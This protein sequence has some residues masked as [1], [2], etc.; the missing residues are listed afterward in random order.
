MFEEK[1]LSVV[2]DSEL[3]F[4]EHICEK[5]RKANCFNGLIWRSFS[6]L[7]CNMFLK[8]YTFVRPHLEFAQAVWATF[9]MKYVNMIENL[10]LRATK[11]VDG[12]G[13]FE[14]KERLA[15]LNL[16][17]LFYRRP[18]GDVIETYKHFHEY[19]TSFGSFLSTTQLWQPQV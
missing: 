4:K 19:D 5:V 12:L 15:R 9:M 8:I 14:Y 13:E 17:I 3:A 1:D 16:P 7:D 10:Q 2:F 18:R 6:Y 11:L